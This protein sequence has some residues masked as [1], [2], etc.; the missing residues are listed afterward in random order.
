MGHENSK[1]DYFQEIRVQKPADS[2]IEQIRELI[3]SGTLKAGDRLPSERALAERFG[4]GRGHIRQ[5]LKKLEFYG[6]LKTLPQRGT[7]V[8]SLSVKALEGL[9]SNILR[10][11]QR[12]FES[13]FE[14]R[15]ILEVHAARTAAE[16]ATAEDL[17]ELREA[18]MEFCRQVDLGKRALEEDH[19]FHLKIAE[20]S[21]NSILSSL[22]GLITPDIIAMNRNV[23]EEASDARRSTVNEHAEVIE[24]IED[25]DPT[26]AAAAMTR[27]MELSRFRRFEGMNGTEKPT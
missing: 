20:S 10:I 22:I 15:T 25:H 4:V 9:I 17:T 7:V 3:R 24:A 8:A 21:K 11:D 5:A 12:D 1:I 18:H 19:V 23:T 26:A 6:I 27:H 14:T 13:L 16:R 2:I